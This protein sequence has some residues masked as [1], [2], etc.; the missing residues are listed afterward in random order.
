MLVGCTPD[1]LNL[2]ARRGC[3]PCVDGWHPS[4]GWCDVEIPILPTPMSLLDHL[5]AFIRAAEARIDQLEDAERAALRAAFGDLADRVDLD[6]DYRV[7]RVEPHG[8]A[9]AYRVDRAP[10]HPG[11]G[12][13]RRA[14]ALITGSPS[15]DRQRELQDA[16]N[17][18]VA[19]PV[20]VPAT[21]LERELRGTRLAAVDPTAADLHD[22]ARPDG[23]T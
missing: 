8:I 15:W 14:R 21:R 18:G 20:I 4:A 2:P 10:R 6:A 19:M 12:A 17:V 5:P 22:L 13:P 1:Y 7:F 3:H 23:G 11:G 9:I 16:F